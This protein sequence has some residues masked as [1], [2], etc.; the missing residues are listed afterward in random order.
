MNLN[1]SMVRITSTLL[2]CLK[3]FV[4]TVLIVPI[5]TFGLAAINTG[6]GNRHFL[7][8]MI[9]IAYYGLIYTIP[10]F[11]LTF[12]IVW[13]LSKQHLSF[14]VIK[15][16]LSITIFVLMY[17]VPNPMPLAEDFVLVSIYYAITLACIWIYKFDSAK[18]ILNS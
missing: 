13:S 18:P 12:I 9:L 1:R 5:T 15:G 2:Y 3:I 10:S 16:I 7:N 14:Y 8:F 17:S 4:T 11:V 6:Q